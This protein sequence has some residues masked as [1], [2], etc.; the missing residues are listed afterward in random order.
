MRFSFITIIVFGEY[1]A[2]MYMV[3]WRRMCRAL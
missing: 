2:H 3:M 1:S